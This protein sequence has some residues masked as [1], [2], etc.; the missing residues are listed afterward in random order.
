MAK[1]ID[2]VK[3]F[4]TA[5]TNIVQALGEVNPREDEFDSLLDK[6]TQV[7]RAALNY[8]DLQERV[9]FFLSEMAKVE[10]EIKP[11]D[12]ITVIDTVRPHEEPVTTQESVVVDKP[13]FPAPEENPYPDE[14]EAQ[15]APLTFDEVKAAFTKAAQ[16]G[17]PV[18]PIINELG[19]EKLSAVPAEKYPALMEQLDLAIKEKS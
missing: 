1:N 11:T 6:H 18:K 15:T 16:D 2:T 19:Y 17:V 13:D 4:I 12:N 5:A 14:P 3:S 8:M 10:E 7:C 9:S